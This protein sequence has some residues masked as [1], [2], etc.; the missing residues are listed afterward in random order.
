[1]SRTTVSSTTVFTGAPVARR[2]VVRG[3]ALLVPALGGGVACDAKKETRRRTAGELHGRI[4]D[5]VT[6]ELPEGPGATVLVARGSELLYCEGFGLADRARRVRCSRDTVYDIA[7]NTKQFTAAAVLK[8]EMEGGVHVRDR[9]GDLLPGLPADKRPL[10]VHQ[11][12][13]HT[14]GLPEFLPDRYGDD[15]APL[16]RAELIEALAHTDAPTRPG[17]AFRYSNL[18]YSLLAAVI[19]VRSG[20]SYERFLADRLFRPAGLGRTGYVRP[21]WR[22]TDIAVEY[23]ERGRPAGRPNRRP[24]AP[25]GPHWN[26][27]G[28]GGLLSTAPDLFRWHTALTGTEVLSPTARHKLF[29]RHVSEE[30]GDGPAYGYGWA[31]DTGA[32]GHLIASHTGQSQVG[33]SYSE[34]ARTVDGGAFAFVAT[35]YASR[36]G[37]WTLVDHGLARELVDLVETA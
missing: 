36:R 26:L 13:T 32:G 7:S 21:R 4:H 34:I 15:Y 37:R 24:S 25:D 20:L 23:D 9:L 5:V 2:A 28:N 8:L 35:N 31:L 3:A 11:L 6:A 29:T 17:E 22:G 30:D 33:G 14:S 27:R 12:L 1:M 16:S 19:E 10:T 18:G